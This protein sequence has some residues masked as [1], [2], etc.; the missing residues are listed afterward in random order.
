LPFSFLISLP[1]RV[2]HFKHKYSKLRKF[3]NNRRF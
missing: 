3:L 2:L 1:G